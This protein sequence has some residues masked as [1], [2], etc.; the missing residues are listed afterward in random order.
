MCELVWGELGKFVKKKRVRRKRTPYHK[1]QSLLLEG[2]T[3]AA[4]YTGNNS[5]P[6]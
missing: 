2:A 1:Y 5:T 3:H 6:K 4:G